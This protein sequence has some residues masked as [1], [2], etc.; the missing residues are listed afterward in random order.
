MKS[1]IHF[2]LLLL[3][4]FIFFII[5]FFVVAQKTLATLYDDAIPLRENR[6]KTSDEL[7]IRNQ[8]AGWEDQ[9][10]DYTCTTVYDNQAT[11]P[12]PTRLDNPTYGKIIKTHQVLAGSASKQ[13]GHYAEPL[14]IKGCGQNR[15]ETE[16]YQPL[17]LNRS[18]VYQGVN[19]PF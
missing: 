1:K 12:S 17:Q 14:K 13:E 3:L 5:I 6:V 9:K 16:H 7:A 10:A 19:S 2:L 18:V 15:A 4:F 11:A 8:A